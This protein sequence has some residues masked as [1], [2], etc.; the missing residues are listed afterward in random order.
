MASLEYATPG[1]PTPARPS[2]VGNALGWFSLATFGVVVLC[3]LCGL[4]G[5]L[6]DPAVHE[7]ESWAGLP[8][9]FLMALPTLF[10]CPLG[11]LAG[12][13]GIIRGSGLAW[14]AFLLN[15]A[16]LIAFFLWRNSN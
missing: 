15:A 12:L 3:F 6:F 10:L 1:P 4:A 11:L 16:S 14:A 2:V 8:Y 7:P 13:F 9:L 5:A